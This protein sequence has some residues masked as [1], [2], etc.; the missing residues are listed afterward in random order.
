VG[1]VGYLCLTP[2]YEDTSHAKSGVERCDRGVP[3]YVIWK[4]KSITGHLVF[5]GYWC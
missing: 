4:L 1:V 3:S 5:R 2:I